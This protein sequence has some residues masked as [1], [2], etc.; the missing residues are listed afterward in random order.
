MVDL[1]AM[2]RIHE[3]LFTSMVNEV[4]GE[5]GSIT[6][7]KLLQFIHDLYRHL[8]IEH[9][10]E[11]LVVLKTVNDEPAQ[12]E[13]EFVEMYALDGFSQTH[14][15]PLVVQILESGRIL[16][17]HSSVDVTSLAG[18]AVVY[19][20]HD[21]QEW[22]YA[23]ERVSP[24]DKISAT[25]SSNFAL[26]IFGELH[27]ALRHYQTRSIRHSACPIFNGCWYDAKRIFLRASP[28]DLMR[29]SLTKFLRDHMRG[30]V[31]VHPEQNVDTTKPVDIKVTWFNSNR[32]ALIEIKWLGK[33]RNDTKITTEYTESRAREGAEQLV[34]YLE[35]NK[36]YSPVQVTRGYLVVIDARRG[37]TNIDTISLTAEHGLKYASME[38][39]YNPKFHEARTD[40]EAPFRMFAEPVLG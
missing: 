23:K 2:V 3:R 34:D 22:F 26:P 1:S 27:D 10:K 24:V 36:P 29:D 33:S 5:A 32:L 19:K 31:E 8:P 16:V 14:T 40:F 35:R 12:V 25:F 20:H 15:G 37:K 39:T 7:R 6:L 17:W 9:R 28:E 38:I 13:G 18:N 21:R 4:F 11:P 30:D